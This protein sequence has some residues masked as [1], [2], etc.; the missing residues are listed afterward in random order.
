MKHNQ[1]LENNY[2]MNYET[3]E[4]KQLTQKEVLTQNGLAFEFYE[5]F[6]KEICYFKNDRYPCD[7]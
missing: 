6:T 1:K 4:E 5:I 7:G 2:V 3:G